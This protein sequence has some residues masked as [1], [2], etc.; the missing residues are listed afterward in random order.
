MIGVLGEGHHDDV[1][2][3]QHQT[4]LNMASWSKMIFGGEAGVFILFSITVLFYFL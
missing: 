4:T 3:G 1:G 2:E